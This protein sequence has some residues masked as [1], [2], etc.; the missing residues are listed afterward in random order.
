MQSLLT[1]RICNAVRV[2]LTFVSASGLLM[3]GQHSPS[4]NC[5]SFVYVFV[6]FF[7]MLFFIVSFPFRKLQELKAEFGLIA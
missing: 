6:I 2:D 5:D 7:F 1:W 3:R 4:V